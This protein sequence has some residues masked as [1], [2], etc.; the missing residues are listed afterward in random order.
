MA[1]QKTTITIPLG[2][3]VNTK[4][5]E[6]LVEQGRFN[7]VCE[8]ATFDKVGAV[9]KRQGVDNLAVTYYNPDSTDGTAGNI[10]SL[11]YKPTMAS[12]LESSTFLRCKNGEYL[13]THNEAYVYRPSYPIPE[14]R[15]TSKPIYSAKYAVLDGDCDYDSYQ[16]IILT[17]VRDSDGDNAI[18]KL[19]IYDNA[20]GTA[21]YS[22]TGGVIAAGANSAGPVRTG[23]SR[24]GGQSYYYLIYTDTSQVL[25]IYTFNAFGQ[26]MGTPIT[27]NN[28]PSDNPT[29]TSIGSIG[30]CRKSDDSAFYIMA[31]TTT[32]SVGKFICMV[33]SSATVNTTFSTTAAYTSWYSATAKYDSNLSLIRLCFM[34]P[35]VTSVREMLLTAAGAVNTTDSE[36][37]T[38]STGRGL[39]YSAHNNDIAYF[40]GGAGTFSSGRWNGT[41]KTVEG[42]NTSVH[43]D[44]Q[45]TDAGINFSVIAPYYATSGDRP[46]FAAPTGTLSPVKVFARVATGLGA[47]PTSQVPRMAKISGTK[48]AALVP[49]FAGNDGSNSRYNANL[50]FFEILQDYKSN[51]RAIIGKNL[52]IQG[53]FI[54][55]FDGSSLF[56]NGFHVPPIEPTLTGTGTGITGT[57]SYKAVFKYTDKNGQITRSAPSATSSITVTN[58][59]VQITLPSM[60]FGVK[61]LNCEVEIYRTTNGGSSF[62]LVKTVPATTMTTSNFAWSATIAD[63]AAD[64]SIT[65]NTILYTSGNIL[66]ND[67]AP[68]CK[69]V[70]QG[71]NRIF[72]VGLEDENEMAYSKEKLF[73][74]CANF[75]DFFRIR[76]DTA[77]YNTA[78]G[79]TAG[80]FMDDKVVL[81]KRNSIFFVSGVGPNETGVGGSYSNPELISAE[82]GCTDPRSVILTPK[83]LMFKGDKGIYLLD[84]GL[85]TSYI[86][87]SIEE[88]NTYSV[89]G[90]VHIDKKNQVVFS[91]KK[92]QLNEG[93]LAVYD[94]YTEQ[95]SIVPDTYAIDLDV[96]DGDLLVLNGTTNV[97]QVQDGSD[98]TDN[99]SVYSMKVKTPW[100]KV[101]GVQDY[102]R[103]WSCTV[104]GKYKSAHD[105]IVKARYDYDDDY[106]E[107]Y[108]ITPESTDEQYQYRVHLQKQKCEAVQFEIYDTNQTGESMELTAITLEVGVKKGAMKLPASRKY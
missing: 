3:G 79:L 45:S 32:S 107:T 74:E 41:T 46:Y 47:P 98:F 60:P 105:L 67:P 14:C 80:G 94:Y 99:S 57:Y 34:S 101:S 73:G 52:H 84:R 81:F 95:W 29:H 5:D 108:T 19:C 103:I 78:G 58:K 86:G 66:D 15:V 89:T 25:H 40:E 69:S 2:L 106:V 12:A 55:E 82:T 65:D 8:N 64:A 93:V 53:G 42:Y 88:Y 96:V 49:V 85:N 48:F 59:A 72:A 4:T 56:E 16:D 97:P 90:A 37:F 54:S 21:A 22:S 11:T 75:S 87:A 9:K 13:Y 50:V 26:Q 20:S 31:P 68:A 24:S 1:L 33:G 7:L 83:G 43:S 17:A 77:Q 76:V 91:L 102:A 35:A 30:V 70:F 71:G 63:Q 36:I 18:A 92:P 104:L 10:T 27:V 61:A 39:A 23:M 28:I 62:Y 38:L 51:G 6:K 44:T 100:I